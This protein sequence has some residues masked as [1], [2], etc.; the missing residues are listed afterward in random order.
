MAVL[1]GATAWAVSFGTLPRAN[2]TF[3]NGTEIQSVDPAR[4]DG[5]PEGRI[6]NAIF[7]GL[8]RLDPKTLE[9]VPAVALRHELSKD[10]L[11][12]TFYVRPAGYLLVWDSTSRSS[13]GRACACAMPSCCT[14][15]RR[16]PI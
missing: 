3:I 12:Y 6:I 15:E 13:P 8:Y 7:E 16:T 1:L 14:P 4:V 9:P 5:A 10:N 11:T 2:F